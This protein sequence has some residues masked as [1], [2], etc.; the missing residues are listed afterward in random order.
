[1]ASRYYPRVEIKKCSLLFILCSRFVKK[2]INLTY[3]KIYDK[4]LDAFSNLTKKFFPNLLFLIKVFL[5]VGVGILLASKV[6]SFLFDYI[7]LELLC[8][9]TGFLIGSLIN[10]KK[11]RDIKEDTKKYKYYVSFIIAFIIVISLSILNVYINKNSETGK[12]EVFSDVNIVLMIELFFLSI[13]SFTTMLFPGISGSLTLMIFGLYYPILNQISLL[14]HFENYKDINFIITS[15]K[16]LIPILLG[17]LCAFLFVTKPLNYL[18]KKYHKISLYVI[19]G[20]V[21]ASIISM[22]IL[23][24]KDIASSFSILHLLLSVLAFLPFGY[25][26]SKLLN[27]FAS[28]NAQVQ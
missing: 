12:D 20:F 2:N 14:T 16:I 18:F 25:F 27:H 26:S 3:I 22:F 21:V 5:G 13:I 10:D 8:L 24:Y 6:L 7:L 4:I 15:L 23:N 9:F 19:F 17:G 28:K 11:E 1:M